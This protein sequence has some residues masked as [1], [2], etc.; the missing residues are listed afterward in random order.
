MSAV[1]HARSGPAPGRSAP[2]AASGRRTR[3][4]PSRAAWLAAFLRRIIIGLGGVGLGLG[5]TQLCVTH[6]WD[7]AAVHI[8]AW[9][10]WPK[11]GTAEIDPYARAIFA[12]SGELA[13]SAGE[14]VVFTAKRDD[15]GDRL[16]RHC[17]YRVAG[18]VPSARLWTLAALGTEGL[19]LPNAADRHVLLSSSVLRD[20]HGDAELIVSPEVQPGNWLPLSG[21]GAFLLTL[22]LYDTPIGGGG[23]DASKLTLPSITP[24]GCN[25]H[26]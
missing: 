4:G 19:P 2:S 5:L 16:D 11:S 15:R 23:T 9:T 1:L 18:Q 7:V 21:D 22:H 13:L 8:G 14:G 6:R 12:R 3:H 17:T 10:F 26:A 24:L 20:S 25:S